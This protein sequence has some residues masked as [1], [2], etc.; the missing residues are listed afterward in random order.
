MRATWDLVWRF[1]EAGSGFVSEGGSGRNFSFLLERFWA[2]RTAGGWPRT[3]LGGW[4]PRED[5]NWTV[6]QRSPPSTTRG[7]LG[8]DELIVRGSDRW[9]WFVRLAA[10]G[11][12]RRGTVCWV[13]SGLFVEDQWFVQ[14][15]GWLV[16]SRPEVEACKDCSSRAAASRDSGP[17][18]AVAV[19]ASRSAAC[20]PDAWRIR[21]AEAV[22]RRSRLASFLR[23]S[24][25]QSTS[26]YS[27]IRSRYCN[28]ILAPEKYRRNTG[29]TWHLSHKR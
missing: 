13:R 20:G 10:C 25:V 12:V 17:L 7:A 2:C 4:E 16:G 26:C 28:H 23:G 14:E 6:R 21:L 1:C 27:W 29:E 5:G 24:T 11:V 22:S 3:V 8:S 18:Q 19:G 9:R 15:V